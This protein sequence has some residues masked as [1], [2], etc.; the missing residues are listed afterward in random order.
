M[1]IN[2]SIF[3][4]HS[5]LHCSSNIIYIYWPN[6]WMHFSSFEFVTNLCA[7]FFI[8]FLFTNYC[9]C[10][11]M[12]NTF[13][14]WCFFKIIKYGFPLPNIPPLSYVTLLA[15]HVNL[16]HCIGLFKFFI[17]PLSRFCDI[18]DDFV[19][20]NCRELWQCGIILI[21]KVCPKGVMLCDRFFWLAKNLSIFDDLNIT[22]NYNY[23]RLIHTFFVYLLIR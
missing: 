21:L 17:F 20:A 14:S 22:N 6:C 3:T 2:T 13:Q 9:C 4:F 8:V 5:M 19:I 7:H 23:K 15:L 18:H 1:L 11:P 16:I 10:D 12:L